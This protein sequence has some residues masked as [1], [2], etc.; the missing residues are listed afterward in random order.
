M[1]EIL[2]MDYDMVL[3]YIYSKREIDMKEIGK[4]EPKAV[5]EFFIFLMEIYMKEHLRKVL[6]MEKGSSMKNPLIINTKKNGIKIVLL[7]ES[8]SHEFV[9]A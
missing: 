5:K 4:M 6:E 3:V 2:K 8:K 7:P 9:V 1:K